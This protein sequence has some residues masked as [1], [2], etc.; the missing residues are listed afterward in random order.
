MSKAD[1]DAQAL[2]HA[3]FWDERYTKSDGSGPTHEWFRSYSDL[4]PFLERHLFK[5]YPPARNPGILHLG[6][7]DSTVPKD[8][9]DHGYTNQ[10]CL[11]FS[12]VLVK[13]MDAKSLEGLTWVC[14]DVRDMPNIESRSIDVAFDKGTLDAM[15]HGS[16]WDPPDEVKDNTGRYMKEVSRTLKDDGVFLYVTYRQPHFVKPLLNQDKLWDLTTEELS[17]G[18][19]SFDYY[20]FVLKKAVEG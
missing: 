11:D 8:L 2:A 14:E 18:G 4:E 17:G 16:P 12:P 6:A 20:A 9:L 15:I 10:I 19:N 7:G 1:K 13:L 5:T 3:E